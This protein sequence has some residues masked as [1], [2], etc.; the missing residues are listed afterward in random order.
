MSSHAHMHTHD[1]YRI[2]FH[3]NVAASDYLWIF[4]LAVGTKIAPASM[5]HSFVLCSS[6]LSVRLYCNSLL[7]NCF[8]WPIGL[9]ADLYWR[10]HVLTDSL[11]VYSYNRYSSYNGTEFSDNIDDVA[12]EMP[13]G[14]EVSKPWQTS[15]DDGWQYANE[16]QAE[17][18][19]P[20]N[21]DRGS[22]CKSSMERL[23]WD[24]P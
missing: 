19:F 21:S 20:T 3:C 8:N 14:W 4:V 16:F 1:L 22:E 11:S 15:G 10:T 6:I 9:L 24:I 5:R 23:Q 2:Q 7:M 17:T 18:W 13:D 12:P